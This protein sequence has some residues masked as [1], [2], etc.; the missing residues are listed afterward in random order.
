MEHIENQI[1]LTAEDFELK[2]DA[3]HTFPFY[4]DENAYGVYGYGHGDAT[5]FANAVNEYDRLAD[6]GWETG[7]GYTGEDV[8]YGWAIGFEEYQYGG[9]WMWTRVLASGENVSEQ[10]PGAFPVMWVNR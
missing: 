6:A 7:D 9:E 5:E 4:E 2:Y 8:M 1:I 10:T 3:D